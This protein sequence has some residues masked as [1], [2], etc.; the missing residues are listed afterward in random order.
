MAYRISRER[1]ATHAI[2][3]RICGNRRMVMAGRFFDDIAI[4]QVFETEPHTVSRSEILSFAES[5]D[6]NPFHLDENAANDVGLPS[7]IASGLHT[8]SLSFRLFF[9][10]HLWDEAIMPSPG[11][12]RV[13]WLK[14]LLPDQTI[15][16]RAT[17]VDT[18]LWKPEYGVVRMHHETLET[19]SNNP[20][21]TVDAMHRLRRHRPVA[22]A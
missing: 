11:I 16:V 17:V 14:P 20:I 4:G 9:D 8:L 13:R 2:S 10:L 5:F 7:V 22:D 1:Q 15:R 3:W 21:L 12:D 19:A 6:P 18:K